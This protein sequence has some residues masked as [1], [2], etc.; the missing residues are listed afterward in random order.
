[1]LIKGKDLDAQQLKYHI[2]KK[3]IGQKNLVGHFSRIQDRSL[4]AIF[5]WVLHRREAC[6]EK[7]LEQ[8]YHLDVKV[9]GKGQ[10]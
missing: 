7:L 9:S 6:R 2:K 4:C 1:M 3:T 8:H 5:R 10:C